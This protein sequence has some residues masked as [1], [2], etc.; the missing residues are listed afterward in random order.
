MKTIESEKNYFLTR[1]EHFSQRIENAKNEF[2]V[3][4]HIFAII[5]L[6]QKC[7][8]RIHTLNSESLRPGYGQE[9]VGKSK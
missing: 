7:H 3:E 4:G 2:D 5:Q 8:E 1:L 6:A 9:L